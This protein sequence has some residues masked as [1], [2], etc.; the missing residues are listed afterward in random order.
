MSILQVTDLSFSYEESYDPVFQNVS[1]RVDTD[2]R[3]GV[4]GRNGKGKTTFLKLLMGEMEYSGSIT[5]DVGFD[6]FPYPVTGRELDTIDAMY[7]LEPGLLLW[8]LKKDMAELGADEDILYRP[9]HTLSY[10]EQT[11][12]MLAV[13]FQREGNFLLIDE[14]TNH[15]DRESRMLVSAFLRRQKG[16]LMVSHDRSFLD[17][18]IDHVLA[19]NRSD[20]EVQKGDF[21]SWYQNR[22]MRDAFELAENERLKKDIRRLSAAADRTKR[23]GD[24]V[25]STKI[26]KKSMENG[27]H[28]ANRDYIGEKSRRMQQ[29]RKNL[30]RRQEQ[31]I[32]EKKVLLRNQEDPDILRME[33]L[34]YHKDALI[35]SE[36]LTL[37]YGKHEVCS[38]V[39]LVV[40]RGERIS[41]QGKNGCG[42]SSILKLILGEQITYRGEL[43]V[44]S[45]LKISYVS[46]DT[47]HLKGSLSEYI[48]E[49]GIEE[50]LFKTVLRKLDFSRVQLEKDMES[51]SEGQKK[52]VLIAGSLCESAHLYIWDEP[53]NFIDVYSRIQ[54]EDLLLLWKPTLLFVEHDAAF[55][56][57]IAT[58]VCRI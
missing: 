10:G 31:A 9:F 21:S 47:S 11:K 4:V 8:K 58:S 27:Q 7:C 39:N 56:E 20:I 12:V 17:G 2:W 40:R 24:A 44:G 35:S 50:H 19:F 25:E 13:L 29:R 28:V 5:A 48:R 54:I 30:A 43:K 46:Q 55:T 51:Y 32:Q 1:F 42:K 16:F 53:L 52:K 41:V 22:Q 18:C 15:L 38:G 57:K 26:G 37:Y 34:L 36:D 6:Y 23:W 45:G 33:P 14:P 49:S 3:T